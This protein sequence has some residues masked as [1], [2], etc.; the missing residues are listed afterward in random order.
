VI[1]NNNNN[2]QNSHLGG[3]FTAATPVRM[4]EGLCV[5]HP[6]GATD[7]EVATTT[8]RRTFTT[9]YKRRIVEEA[10]ACRG[11]GQIG[12][13]LRREGLYS[14]HLVDWR[15]QLACAPKR[16]GRK[17]MD[18]ALAAQIEI[19]R[20]LLKEKARLEQRLAQAEVIIDVQKKLSEILGIPLDQSQ[21]EEND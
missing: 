4:T 2:N 3:T 17:P 13:L 1:E 5:A 10:A 11:T 16:R 19:N 14:S 9:E 6:V 18:P 12:A 7:P 21:S 15:K 8:R 20:K